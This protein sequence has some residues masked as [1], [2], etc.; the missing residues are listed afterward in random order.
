[1]VSCKTTKND[2][3][4]DEDLSNNEL[5]NKDP[6]KQK[7]MLKLC[8]E[9]GRLSPLPDNIENYNIFTEGDRFTRAFTFTFNANH[10]IIKLWL[11]DCP[12]IKDAI[13]ENEDK[14]TRY[15]IKPGSGASR[16]ILIIYWDKN[17]VYFHTYW[18]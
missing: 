9:W 18:S 2:S 13:V 7:E 15:I 1:M 6:E 5:D 3:N 16:A 14:I 4:S 10:E 12:S 17:Q 11:N 8:I